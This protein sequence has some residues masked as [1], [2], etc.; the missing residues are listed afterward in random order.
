MRSPADPPPRDAQRLMDVWSRSG[1]KY[2]VRAVVLLVVN[3]I[4][5]AA[6]G[7]FAFWLRSG[8]WFAPLTEGFW[9]QLVTAFQFGSQN[10]LTL[11]SLLM[12]PI[13]VHDVPMQIPIFGLLMAA[14]IA[15]P[16][17]VS[18]LYRFPSCLPFIAVV[19]LLAVMPW[20]A[21]TLLGSC[22]LA[23]VRPFRTRFRFVSALMALVPIVIYL[24][25]AWQGSAEAI[26][27]RIDPIDR[28]KLVAPWVLAIVAAGATFAI[29]L[30]IARIVDY[31]PGAITPLLAVMFALPFILFEV[32]VGR[33]ELYYRLLERRNRA[34]FADVD[35]SVAWLDSARRAW[36]RL[37]LPRPSWEAMQQ[38]AAQQWLFELADDLAPHE[39]AL[40]RHVLD[41]TQECDRFLLYFPDSRYAANVLYIKAQAM[42]MRID[43]D[44]FRQSK[45]IRFYA[46]FPNAA[47]HETWRI[48]RT[49]KPDSPLGAAAGLRLAQLNARTG[50]VERARDQVRAVL[51]RFDRPGYMPQSNAD[52]SGA[53]TSVLA[54]GLPEQSLGIDMA[55]ILLKAH[56]LYNLISN[57]RDPL[58]GYEPISGPIS[59]REGFTFGLLD[60]DPRHSNYANNLKV[61]LDRYPH[62]QIED[63]ILVERAKVETDIERRI[64]TLD[65]CLRRF[66]DRDAAPEA[67]FRLSEA[68][69]SAGRPQEASS[70]TATLLNNF[71]NDVWAKQAL[72]QRFQVAASRLT[73]ASP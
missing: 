9:D 37:P 71:P 36:V 10:Q 27:G 33:D 21:L 34:H 26:V 4:L 64:D 46:D 47:S 48:I 40:S 19:G 29:V 72:Q 45:W 65:E 63:N 25:L 43:V 13:N 6:L 50:Q 1:S 41:L 54:R 55:R 35:A 68:L 24:I 67:M 58:Y 69:R 57:N 12:E 5:F 18:I 2:R 22:V 44:E 38:R 15:I 42:S 51:D 70:I 53:L 30:V 7:G 66:P 14:L 20:L 28:I 8:V 49:N 17:L 23:S 31:R 62:C 60:L 73:Q 16:I 61:I 32:N 56:R 39:S 3:I 52:S 59:G 11:A